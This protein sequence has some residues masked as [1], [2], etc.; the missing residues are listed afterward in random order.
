MPLAFS[1]VVADFLRPANPQKRFSSDTLPPKAKSI[2]K[3][4]IVAAAIVQVVVAT[5]QSTQT[6]KWEMPK[7]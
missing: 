1:V 2:H 7:Q 3:A 6:Y 4:A 5:L